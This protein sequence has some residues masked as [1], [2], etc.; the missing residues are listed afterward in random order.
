M[1]FTVDLYILQ[2]QLSLM[3]SFLFHFQRIIISLHLHHFNSFYSPFTSQF[4]HLLSILLTSLPF[5]PQILQQFPLL[6]YY[7]NSLHFPSIPHYFTSLHSN[8]T[9][10]TFTSLHSPITSLT[11]TSLHYQ[12]TLLP[13]LIQFPSLPHYFPSLCFHITSLHSSIT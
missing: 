9:S 11:F 2:P 12:I 7:F 6:L 10:L 4:L 8:V 5:T 13:P 3:E 1:L